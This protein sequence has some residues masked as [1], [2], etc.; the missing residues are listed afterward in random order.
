MLAAT[1]LHVFFLVVLFGAV[2]ASFETH[3]ELAFALNELLD[4]ELLLFFVVV[5]LLDRLLL[6]D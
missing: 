4:A 3:V 5:Q 1:P 2:F 6:V